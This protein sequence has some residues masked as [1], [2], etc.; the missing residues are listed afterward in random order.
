M[1]DRNDVV[2]INKIFDK[3]KIVNEGSLDFAISSTKKTK[4]WITQ[5][6]YFLR[7]IVVDHAFE[8]GN[9]RTAAAIFIAY[10]EASKRAYDVYKIDLI[11]KNLIQKRVTDITKI[12]RMIKNAVV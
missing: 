5:L 6:A 10:C 1:L 12:R 2:G 3:G 7:A 8:E 9:K 11:I 4:D